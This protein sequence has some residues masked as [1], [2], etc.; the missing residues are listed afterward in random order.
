[1]QGVQY[2]LRNS[3]IR[4]GNT[5]K[6]HGLKAVELRCELG[7]EFLSTFRQCKPSLKTGHAL[8]LLQAREGI[9]GGNPGQVRLSH[10]L[11]ESGR[12]PVPQCKKDPALRQIN[13]F[14]LPEFVESDRGI[15]ANECKHGG[16]PRRFDHCLWFAVQRVTN[17]VGGASQQ[18]WMVLRNGIAPLCIEKSAAREPR[19]APDAADQDQVI[20][21]P[22]SEASSS[23]SRTATTSRSTG[24]PSAPAYQS[25]PANLSSVRLAKSWDSSI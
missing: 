7:A 11:I 15:H 21:P 6:L 2:A 24:E 16:E 14:S 12:I 13:S 17:A 19:V 8:P 20:S 22:S 18:S 9:L 10:N 25:T 23:Q 5:G 1:V 4:C 3:E